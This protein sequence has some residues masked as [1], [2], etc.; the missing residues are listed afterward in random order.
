MLRMLPE[1]PTDTLRNASNV[2]GSTVTPHTHDE[3]EVPMSFREELQLT[4]SAGARGIWVSSFEEP[5]VHEEIC[6]VAAEKGHPLFTWSSASG[7]KCPAQD[8]TVLLPPSAKIS[9][10][11]QYLAESNQE[12]MCVFF[13]IHSDLETQVLRRVREL[14]LYGH[15]RCL[16][17]TPKTEIPFELTHEF[18]SL[19]FKLPTVDELSDVIKKFRDVP[20]INVYPAAEAAA[21]L[22]VNEARY[23]IRRAT[24]AGQ[25][26]AQEMAAHIWAYKTTQI[27]QSG[28][29]TISKP[30]ETWNDVAG[31]YA[32]REWVNA[33]LK[34]FAPE[35]RRKGVPSPR[36]VLF[37]GPFGTGKSL[38]SKVIASKLGWQYVEWKLDKLMDPFVGNTESNTRRMIELTELHAPCVVRIDEI[39]NQVSG[40]ESSGYT[41]SGVVSR[42]IGTILTWME[43]RTSDIFLAASTNEPWKLPGHMVRAGRF[44][45]IFYVGLPKADALEEVLKL[46]LMKYSPTIDMTAVDIPEMAR[47]MAAEKFSAAE[48]EQVVIESVQT[49]YPNLPDARH[50][51]RA[52][53]AVVPSAV[54]MAEQTKRIEEWARTRAQSADR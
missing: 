15:C 33:R 45:A 31:M 41:D 13:D 26:R 4:L 38:I 39:T 32:F 46:K 21:G 10:A 44:D 40:H 7:L 17:V 23:A 34:V 35:A 12:G 30:T 25:K 50:L 48:A 53:H 42:M 19:P 36:G 20:A 28:M 51:Q 9:G 49:A 43:E 6:A 37:V 2:R 18:V 47:T 5:R 1:A 3:L 22:T 29:I 8:D 14:V 27:S 16:I 11:L 24:L 52:L 54:T